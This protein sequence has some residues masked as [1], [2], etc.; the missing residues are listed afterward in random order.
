[1]IK[2]E[3]AS[4]VNFQLCKSVSATLKAQGIITQEDFQRL[5]LAAAEKYH[6]PIGELEVNSIA[7]EKGCKG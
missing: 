6:A 7:A 3:C 4:K 2:S 5:S 1:M